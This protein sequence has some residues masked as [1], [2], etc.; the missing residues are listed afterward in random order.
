MISIWFISDGE[1]LLLSVA[2]RVNASG[3]RDSGYI[4][5]VTL[6][7]KDVVDCTSHE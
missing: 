3:K 5:F 1:R 4:E 6:A 7:F 2:V